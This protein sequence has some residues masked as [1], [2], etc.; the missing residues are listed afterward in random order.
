MTELRKMKFDLPPPAKPE[1][2]PRKPLGLEL[3]LNPVAVKGNMTA[4]GQNG[5]VGDQPPD[6]EPQPHRGPEVPGETA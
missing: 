6:R 4:N 2:F 1:E 3:S 5:R